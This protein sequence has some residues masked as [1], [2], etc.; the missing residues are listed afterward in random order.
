M[1]TGD[2]L[3]PVYRDGLMAKHEESHGDKAFFVVENLKEATDGCCEYCGDDPCTWWLYG[4]DIEYNTRYENGRH[5]MRIGPQVHM[6]AFDRMRGRF[7]H[8]RDVRK[9][10]F[11]E[12]CRKLYDCPTPEEP[13]YPR[14]PL[15]VEQHILMLYP[16]GNDVEKENSKKIATNRARHHKQRKQWQREQMEKKR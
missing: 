9:K 16:E 11:K 14:L 12:F 7:L 2:Y 4:R 8:H 6:F 3:D 5:V 15:C 13:Y 10:L 1:H